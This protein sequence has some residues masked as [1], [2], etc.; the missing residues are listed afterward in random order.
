[1]D[2]NNNNDNGLPSPT[3]TTVA[4]TVAPSHWNPNG[5][6]VILPP[7]SI[8]QRRHWVQRAIVQHEL[9]KSW[10]QKGGKGG[11]DD[12]DKSEATEE[13]STQAAPPQIHPL[14]M[15]SARLQND[16]LNE[17]NRSINLYALVHTGEYFGL[18]NIVADAALELA[19]A[20][21]A[22]T[23]KS[24]VERNEGTSAD[25]TTTTTTTS[26]TG[27]AAAAEADTTGATTT[28][29]ANAATTTAS[30]ESL[31]F[32]QSQMY[33][34]M[35]ILKRKHG[36]FVQA[37]RVLQRHQQRLQRA[38]AAEA[39]PLRRLAQLRHR[40]RL[41]APEHGQRARPHPVRPTEVLAADVDTGGG[42]ST[43]AF[44]GNSSTTSTTTI[45][46][47]SAG[48]LARRIPRYATI[49][50]RQTPMDLSGNN[51]KKAKHSVTNSTKAVQPTNGNGNDDPAAPDAMDVDSPSTEQPNDDTDEDKK[52]NNNH[53]DDDENLCWTYAEPFALA[54]PTLGK[55]DAEFDPSKIEMLTLQFAL[56]NNMD[57]TTVTACLEPTQTSNDIDDGIVDSENTSSPQRQ[58]NRQRQQQPDEAVL[59]E[60]Q[61]SLLCSKLFESMRRELADDTDEVGQVRTTSQQWYKNVVWLA[62][63]PAVATSAVRAA[64]QPHRRP[65]QVVHV[66]EGQV[67]VQLNAQYTLR[68]ALVPLSAAHADA[69]TATAGTSQQDE[70]KGHRDTVTPNLLLCKTLLWKAHSLYHEHSVKEQAKLELHQKL[71]QEEAGIEKPP[72]AK[73]KPLVN[74]TSPHILQ[75]VVHLGTKLL[76][77]KQVRSCFQEIQEWLREEEPP[78]AQPV[79]NGGN[80]DRLV[81]Q[82]TCLSTSLLDTGVHWTLS[83]GTDWQAD[84]TVEGGP[85]ISVQWFT[86]HH[87][88]HNPAQQAA[89]YRKVDFESVGPL[90]LFLLRQCRTLLSR[91]RKAV[92]ISAGT[93]GASTTPV[94]QPVA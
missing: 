87:H 47:N 37:R 84:V 29:T 50:L 45:H 54:D 66:H 23:T 82:I 18:T 6:A 59:Q 4:T 27:T 64:G 38:V 14:A 10:Q 62:A 57:H 77:E 35:Y 48:R 36:Q 70:K 94:A 43:V 80:Q 83:I 16:G 13:P 12:E 24:D 19:A 5:N 53:P 60:L 63:T 21:A 30:K 52:K 2:E 92:A 76:M 49:E 17:L 68:V 39:R 69:T 79:T 42:G 85:R 58:Q 9:L 74:A 73:S 51:T 33:Q 20:A 65:L 90:R 55:L 88:H 3:T 41:V 8:L 26:P 61:H 1:M 28:T 25:G 89:D 11:D 67:C 72:I 56:E 75:G 46:T 81:L 91:K 44:V 22:T 15:A 31:E 32:Q 7:P 71:L 93:N 78:A 86:N 40:W 34:S